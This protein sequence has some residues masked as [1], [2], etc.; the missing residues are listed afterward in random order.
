MLATF[1][2]GKARRVAPG[3]SEQA[4]RGSVN[5]LLPRLS[6]S[7][8][9]NFLPPHMREAAS[10]TTAR[11]CGP[12]VVGADAGRRV[13]AGAVGQPVVDQRQLR[14]ELLCH[15][16]CFGDGVGPADHGQV[17]VVVEQGPQ[18]LRDGPV[19]LDQQHRDE[20]GRAGHGSGPF[21][22]DSPFASGSGR[23][24]GDAGS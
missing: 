3:T 11:R 2:K 5:H 16:H 24:D 10:S 13:G 18:P 12:R 23:V 17:V 4:D 21:G 9:P 15:G 8:G 20:V 1:A 22:V 19:V 14:G 7:G 6:P